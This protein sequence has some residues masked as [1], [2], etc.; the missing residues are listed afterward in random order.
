MVVGEYSSPCLY[1]IMTDTGTTL[2]RNRRHLRKTRE[3]PPQILL[4]FNNFSCDD[5]I[6]TL[7]TQLLIH[8]LSHKQLNS[9]R[10]ALEVVK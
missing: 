6:P 3:A 9:L 2:R 10:D 5:D 7:G 4:D 8:Q 1:N